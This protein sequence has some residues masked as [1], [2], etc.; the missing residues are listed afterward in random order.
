VTL[1]VRS[2]DNVIGTRTITFLRRRLVP[3]IW[4][5]S[6]VIIIIATIAA[7]DD[8]KFLVRSNVQGVASK[9]VGPDFGP[10]LSGQNEEWRSGSVGSCANGVLLSGKSVEEYR[11][12]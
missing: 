1:L 4:V 2:E 11:D 7:D 12:M 8:P 6:A 3:R 10:Y 5:Q 9:N